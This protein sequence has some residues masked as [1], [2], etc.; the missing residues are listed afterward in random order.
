MRALKL[1][2][3][4]TFAADAL[5]VAAWLSAGL[6]ASQSA[7]ERDTTTGLGVV[8]G[9]IPLVMLLLILLLSSRR[10]STVGLWICLAL[11][12]A[13]LILLLDLVAKQNFL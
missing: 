4:L 10:G 12:L 8:F 1:A 3:W 13:P 2:A 11:G 7:L 9:A 6:F 5:V